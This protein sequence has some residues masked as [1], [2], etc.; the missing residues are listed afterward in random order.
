M[1][2]LPRIVFNQMYEF[3]IQTAVLSESQRTSLDFIKII[4]PKHLF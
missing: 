2:D 1:K 4:R 3:H